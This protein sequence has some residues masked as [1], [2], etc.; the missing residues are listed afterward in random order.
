MIKF[1]FTVRPINFDMIGGTQRLAE[2]TLREYNMLVRKAAAADTIFDMY[3]RKGYVSADAVDALM[4]TAVPGY[5]HW[6]EKAARE[7]VEEDA[8]GEDF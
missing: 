4:R 2:V 6:L 5:A 3:Q 8:D 1:D 7:A